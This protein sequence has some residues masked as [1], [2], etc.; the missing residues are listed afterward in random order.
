LTIKRLLTSCFGLGLLPGAPGTWGSLP[1]AAAFGLV[2]YF[3]GSEL[4]GF[5]VMLVFFIAGAVICIRFSDTAIA[6]TGKNDPREVVADE[7]AGQALTFII[8]S[9]SIDAIQSVNR[10]I[11]V[12]AAGFALF[13]LFDIIKPWPVRRL[14]K[15]PGVYGILADDLL[16]GVY[17]GI[18]LV[19]A[20][21]FWILK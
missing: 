5:L 9:F 17:A 13:R 12:T 11:I 2:C 6:A 1:P 19:L 14:E 16:A 8:L 20:A 18:L 7:V 10:L 21:K 15:L 4:I 3:S